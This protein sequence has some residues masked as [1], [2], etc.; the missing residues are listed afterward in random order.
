MLV[1]NVI[2]YIFIVPLSFF[3]CS[4]GVKKKKKK[5]APSSEPAEIL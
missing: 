3:A 5:L 4:L 2:W 1:N